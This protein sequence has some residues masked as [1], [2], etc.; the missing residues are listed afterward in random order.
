MRGVRSQA[1]ASRR[2]P[3]TR[4]RAAA[5]QK[6]YA[7][8]SGVRERS[9]QPQIGW[10]RQG[11]RDLKEAAALD[12]EVIDRLELRREAA[13]CLT[14]LDLRPVAEVPVPPGHK[15]YLLAFHPDG[16]HLV[17]SRASGVYEAP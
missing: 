6:Y 5:T 1:Q 2:R 4:K 14:G 7:L 12:V 3:E 8:L 16:K 13:R 11:L 15:P 9:T 17:S 10:A